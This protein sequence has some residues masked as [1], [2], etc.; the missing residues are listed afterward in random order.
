MK[1][2]IKNYTNGEVT[3]VWKPGICIHS[4]VCFNGLPQ[5]F[6]PRNRPWVNI[7]GADTKRITDQIKQCP[8]GALSY[9]LNSPESDS[10]G[11]RNENILIEVT[12]GGPLLVHGK[13]RLKINEGQIEEVQKITALCRCG[14]S[15]NKP[16][17]DGSHMK[18]KFEG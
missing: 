2:I 18:I 3:V 12:P 10:S 6:D 17:C 11:K 1:E 4:A 7:G 14:V 9:F 16:Y 13:I 8:S 5:V 15:G